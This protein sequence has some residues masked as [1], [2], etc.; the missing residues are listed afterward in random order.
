MTSKR[1]NRIID[2][3]IISL[4][5]E[6]FGI[7]Y[8]EPQSGIEWKVEVPFTMPGDQVRVNLFRKRSGT[9]QSQLLEILVPSPERIKA[10]CIHFASCGGC[11]WQHIPYPLQLDQKVNSIQKCFGDLLTPSVIV[12]PIIPCDP[13]WEYRNKMEFSFSQ[14]LSGERFLG[15]IKQGSKGKVLTLTECHLVKP[16]F[17]EALEAVKTWWNSSTLEAYHLH[18]DKGSL[19]TLMLREGT[20]SGDRMVCL[21]V[22]GNPD[23]ALNKKQLVDFTTL[24]KQTIS[25]S[26][27]G[28]LSI[29]LRIQQIAKGTPTRFYEMLLNEPDQ[30]RE[31]L[32]ISKEDKDIS[33]LEFKISPASFFQPTTTQA[34]KLYSH[35][36]EMA[37][38]TKD[39]VV[40][41]L[42]CG[43]G[44]LGI[45]AATY[46]KFVV[47][48]EISPE[49]SLD[50]RTNA[51]DNHLTNITILTG[52]VGIVLEQIQK[53]G[54]HPLPDVVMVDPPRAGMDEK[55][56]KTL[57]SLNAKT[58]VYVSCNPATQAL[59]I[60]EL[61][62]N[63]Y[64]LISL[65]PVDQFPQTIHVENIA[66]LKK[67]D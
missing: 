60:Q 47:G 1:K 39:C 32:Y 33:P 65:Q 37:Q 14:D 42:F 19:R 54:T 6:G 45:C 17:I 27:G 35:A 49:A 21:T 38:I 4:N 2:V 41:D 9:Y 26:N 23:Y 63:G 16:W 50:A 40:Y 24:L 55:A 48:I 62:K 31:T 36:L 22:S 46:A 57:L 10:R 58:I 53:E 66:L 61:A 51:K 67:M 13:P 18:K 12:H 52:D 28:K 15:L 7:G 59:N 56:I 64:T 25:P 11:R 43:T 3:T 8:H 44:T 29:F 30:I 20:R 34:E 5:K